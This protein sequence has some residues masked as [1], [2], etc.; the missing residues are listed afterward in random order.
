M[1]PTDEMLTVLACEIGKRPPDAPTGDEVFALVTRVVR[2]PDA[3]HLTFAQGASAKLAAF[4]E[5]E[6]QCCASIGWE[7]RDEQGPTLRITATTEQLDLFESL[8]TQGRA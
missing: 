7:L 3:L 4:V 1:K 2:S 6:Q 5:A 8:I